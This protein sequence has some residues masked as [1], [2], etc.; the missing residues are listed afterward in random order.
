MYLYIYISIYLSIYIYISIYIYLYI[1]IYIYVC[2][3]K[4]IIYIY[5]YISALTR[6]VE[7]V[8]GM[9]FMQKNM[10]KQRKEAG[11]LLE[12]LK[13]MEEGKVPAPRKNAV[14]IDFSRN[15]NA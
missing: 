3:C 15:K 13:R 4:H 5:I 11:K 10:E 8:M 9:G 1:Y 7:Q 2:V 12:D 14:C 6:G